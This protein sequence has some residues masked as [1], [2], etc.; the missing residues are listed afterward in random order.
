VRQVLMALVLLSGTSAAEA[1]QQTT[2][3]V[4]PV[5]VTSGLGV[6]FAVPDRAWI[7]ISAESRA[8]TRGKRSD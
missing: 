7:T 2:T 6:V 5:V 3:P 1:Q 8:P 4:E